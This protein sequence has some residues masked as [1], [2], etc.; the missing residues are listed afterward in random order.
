MTV[1]LA[2]CLATG[3]DSAYADDT[4]AVVGQ[5][6]ITAG[7]FIESYGAHLGKIGITDNVDTRMGYLENLVRDEVFILQAK[8][9]HLDTTPA[10]KTAFSLIRQQELLNAYSQLHVLPTVTVTEE[11]LKE[12]Y[13]LLNTKLKVRHLYAPTKEKADAMYAQLHKG[14]T[15]A[16]LAKTVFADP[17]LR[18]TGGLLGFIEIDEMD[19]DFEKAAF[20]LKI[21]EIS[22]PVKTVQGYSIIQVEDIQRNPFVTESEYARS[23]N[24][25]TA[26]VRKRKTEEAAKRFTARMHTELNIRVDPRVTRALYTQLFASRATGE[27]ET[28]T[29]G[30]SAADSAKIIVRTAAGNWTVRKL[31]AAM[32]G[33]IDTQRKWIRTEENFADYCAGVVIR[34]HLI[35]E[36]ENEQLAAAPSFRHTVEYKCDTYLREAIEK[37]MMAEVSVPDDSVRAYYHKNKGRFALPVHMRLSSLLLGRK[38]G[39]DS[40][41]TLLLHGEPFESAA[42]KYSMQSATAEHGGDMG[43][44]R[45]DELGTYG[46][47]IFA[48]HKGEWTGPLM[49]D[50]KFLFVKCTDV[51]DG[52]YTPFEQAKEDIRATLIHEAWY[53]QRDSRIEQMKKAIP[54]RTYPERVIPLIISHQ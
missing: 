27:V 50:G 32:A 8:R 11:D 36:A 23:K 20:G 15:F 21:G 6:A 5:R 52:A 13:I 1:L 19:P 33:A 48:L 42:K 49:E 10:A 34:A 37:H 54:C 22:R 28:T 29:R 18:D 2:M 47:A 41:K 24:R 51:R 45:K 7:A 40:V 43:Y 25:V 46:D 31:A 9:D 35:A 26:F 3:T 4:L 44:F 39:A 38:S 30:L 17:Q 14:K 16:E 53:A 12:F